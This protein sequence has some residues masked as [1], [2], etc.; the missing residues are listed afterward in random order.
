[1][2]PHF[3]F[4][5]NNSAKC[6]VIITAFICLNLCSLS[7]VKA[8]DRTYLSFD[9][10]V[11]TMDKSTLEDVMVVIT[12]PSLTKDSFAYTDLKKRLPFHLSFD[13]VYLINV[14]KPNYS[15]ASLVISTRN[16]PI[17]EQAWGYEF[18]GLTLKLGPKN[19]E[20]E[21]KATFNYLFYDNKINFF[22]LERLDSEGE[23]LALYFVNL[24]KWLKELNKCREALE[25]F[26]LVLE[27]DPKNALAHYH[28]GDCFRELD[29]RE[30]AC[31]HFAKSKSLGIGKI[32]KVNNKY[33][34]EK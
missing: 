10:Q 34:R 33:C 7:S 21:A 5:M 25:M 17:E 4:T 11:E 32:G 3:I 2:P 14:I 24:G 27:Y 18:G 6:F 15:G 23:L 28:L 22:D 29:D 20:T 30:N 16:V 9:F 8:F 31:E 19:L 12:Y 26:E 13:N 1:M